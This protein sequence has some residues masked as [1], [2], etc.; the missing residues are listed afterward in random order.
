MYSS[1]TTIADVFTAVESGATYGLVPFE[2]STFGTV[3]QTLD[4]LITC[5]TR[6]RIVSCLEMKIDHCLLSN[7]LD[8]GLIRKVISHPEALGQCREYLDRE[9]PGVERVETTSTAR[10][11]QIAAG[12]S[13]IA[14]VCSI[15]CCNLFQ[16]EV[17]YLTLTLSL[18][19][20]SLYHLVTRVYKISGKIRQSFS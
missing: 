6:T 7:C 4:S 17:M 5:S 8:P 13:S 9:F 2:N 16:I 12:D 19:S 3:Q 10:A 14:A 11:A 18:I 1:Q 15:V 20:L